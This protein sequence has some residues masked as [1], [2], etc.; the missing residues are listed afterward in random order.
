MKQQTQRKQ[1]TYHKE[2]AYK[3]Q[4]HNPQIIKTNNNQ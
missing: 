1:Q 2:N 3:H 4:S